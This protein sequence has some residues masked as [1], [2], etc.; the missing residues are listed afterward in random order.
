MIVSTRGFACQYFKMSFGDIALPFEINPFRKVC[1]RFADIDQNYF[2]W[3]FMRTLPGVLYT[4]PNIIYMNYTNKIKRCAVP[5]SRNVRIAKKNIKLSS[6]KHQ[7]V[8]NTGD[9]GYLICNV[10]KTGAFKVITL[11]CFIDI[12]IRMKPKYHISGILHTILTKCKLNGRARVTPKG[13]I[14]LPHHI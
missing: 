8:R 9:T 11:I 10:E 1:I 6:L 5:V 7:N 3:D 4:R 14:Y 13:C 2:S 12:H